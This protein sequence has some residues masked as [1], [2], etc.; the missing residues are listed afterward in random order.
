MHT[1]K[2]QW[3]KNRL[4]KVVFDLQRSSASP[5]ER[6]R[7]REKFEHKFSEKYASRSRTPEVNESKKRRVE[8]KER[9]SGFVFYDLP[10]AVYK[11][12]QLFTDFDGLYTK[13]W[14]G[15]VSVSVYCLLYKNLIKKKEVLYWNSLINGGHYIMRRQR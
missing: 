2:A 3:H 1:Y 13:W 6:E 11:N 10:F 8:E 4:I 5:S 9:V 15:V 14:C 12:I 7:E